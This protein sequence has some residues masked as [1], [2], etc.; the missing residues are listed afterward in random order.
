MHGRRLDNPSQ[1]SDSEEKS[2]PSK[3]P[4]SHFR[5]GSGRSGWR[6][7]RYLTRLSCEVGGFGSGSS[8]TPSP[9]H[10]VSPAKPFGR[11]DS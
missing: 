1:S 11:P 3:I 4:P 7:R 6:A 8:E 5:G 9:R 10:V 2:L